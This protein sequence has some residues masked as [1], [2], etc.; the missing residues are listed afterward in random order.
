MNTMRG[1][2]HWQLCTSHHQPDQIPTC[3]ILCSVLVAASLML[4]TWSSSHR[5][6][7]GPS[8]S[9]TQHKHTH[10][11]TYGIYN[12]ACDTHGHQHSRCRGT[13]SL[14]ILS[15][16]LHQPS[17]PAAHTAVLLLPGR[18]PLGG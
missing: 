7:W 10:A 15:Q 6:H 11:Q 13:L 16:L 18:N 1:Q 9:C 4:A 14:T 2:Q 17:R 3:A 5:M 12:K 8:F